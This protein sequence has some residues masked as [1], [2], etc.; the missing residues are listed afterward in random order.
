MNQFCLKTF[1][2]FEVPLVLSLWFFLVGYLLP[3]IFKL[4]HPELLKPI[5]KHIQNLVK[6]LKWK[7]LQ[8]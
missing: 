6:Y 8:K 1:S 3:L 2:F 4:K 5:Q 7:F